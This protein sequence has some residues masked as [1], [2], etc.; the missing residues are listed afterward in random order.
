MLTGTLVMIAGFIP[1]VLLPRV[2]AS[3]ASRY[4]WWS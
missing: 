3:I 1:V 2:Q 4:L